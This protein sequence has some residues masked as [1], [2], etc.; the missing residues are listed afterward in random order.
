[1][2]KAAVIGCGKIGSEF[3]DDP[4]S[5]GNIYAHTHAY[6]ECPDTNLVAVC[7]NDDVKA[8]KCGRRWG[9]KAYRSYTEMINYEKPEIVSVCTPDDT[10][11]NIMIDLIELAR[12][13]EYPKGII[14]EK[15]VATS[16]QDALCIRDVLEGSKTGVTVLVNYPRRYVSCRLKLLVG[17]I[18]KP[19][20]I[21]GL[22]SGNIIHNGTHFID[23]AR[24]LLGEI[25][26]VGIGTH[27]LNT[28][29][30][31]FENGCVGTLNG[32][33]DIPYTLFEINIIGDGGRV[34]MNESG[35]TVERYVVEESEY[36]SG[37]KSLKSNRLIKD[38]MKNT[39]LNAV[40]DMVKCLDTGKSP[41]CTLDDGVRAVEI[42]E[43]IR[44]GRPTY[45]GRR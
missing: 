41:V 38:C 8:D 32:F 10:H 1:M 18:G 25:K 43:V 9:V 28:S 4:K 37:Y 2:Y 15:P 45:V 30:I 33:P 12:A 13:R 11:Y 5:Q 27:G 3:S 42:A 20:Y 21:S 23:L 6:M 44:G 7:D 19:L 16:L 17:S 26:F 24:Y 34:T 29:E 14:L 22:Y 39:T 35:H 36:Y 31:I 40:N